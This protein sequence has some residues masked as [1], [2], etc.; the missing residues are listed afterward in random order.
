MLAKKFSF[1][2]FCI[3]R[4]TIAA[5]VFLLIGAFTTASA[6][7]N[8]IRIGYQPWPGV[9][10]KTQIVSD[11]LNAIGYKVEQ[12]QLQ[13]SIILEALAKGDLDINMG[14]WYPMF[15]RKYDPF[16]EK[17]KVDEIAVNLPDMV[18]GYAVPKYVHEGGVNSFADLHKYADKFNHIFTGIEPGATGNLYLKRAIKANEFD[19]GSWQ[20]RPSSTAA[21]MAEVDRAVK[22][23]KW[24]IFV[25]WKPHWMNA[26]WDLYYVKA[27]INNELRPQHGVV[28][29]I[30][31]PGFADK[32]LN[33]ARFFRQFRVNS[34]I[35]SQWTLKMSQKG[36]S[37]KAVAKGWIKENMGTVAK[38][39]VGVKT[40]DG[41]QSAID[42]VRQVYGS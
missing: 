16:A 30:A 42:A 40:Y 17:H 32:H 21:A 33:A 29:T 11:L 41:K 9:T 25:A 24:I 6:D 20:V 14:I 19:L 28:Y 13:T 3:R 2:V 38:W 27:P 26:K 18:Y 12:K 36:L 5:F 37:P 34:A 4:V 35:Q 22:K 31:T 39:L 8:V 10:V 1:L 15:H 7:T 23:Q